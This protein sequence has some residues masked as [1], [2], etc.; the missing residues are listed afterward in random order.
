MGLFRQGAAREVGD[1]SRRSGVRRR[2]NESYHASVQERQWSAARYALGLQLQKRC[3]LCLPALP[4]TFEKERFLPPTPP[5]FP[6]FTS[7]RPLGV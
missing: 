2:W 6:F 4:L 5:A 1:Q 7:P 3:I